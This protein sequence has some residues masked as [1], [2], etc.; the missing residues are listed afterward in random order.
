MS[1]LNIFFWIHTAIGGLAVL[2]G[3]IVLKGLMQSR[4]RQLWTFLFLCMAVLV[5]L[6]GLVLPFEG[7][8]PVFVARFLTVA[9]LAIAFAARYRYR[10]RGGWRGA[11]VMAIVGTLYFI[12][13]EL[14]SQSFQDVVVHV[15]ALVFFIVTGVVAF[16]KFQPTVLAD[17]LKK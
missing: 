10:L 14:I 12:V 11:Y 13:F 3:A 6:T 1:V 2:S 5:T 9:S 7:I 4:G 8:T 15:A 17:P 16:R